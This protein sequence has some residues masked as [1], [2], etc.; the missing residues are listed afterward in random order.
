MMLSLFTVLFT[1]CSKDNTTVQVPAAGYETSEQAYTGDEIKAFL[2][3]VKGK[4]ELDT[5][6]TYTLAQTIALTADGIL[7]DYSHADKIDK[8]AMVS[9]DSVNVTYSGTP[10]GSADVTSVYNAVLNK[11]SAMANAITTPNLWLLGIDLRTTNVTATSARIHIACIFTDGSTA[12]YGPVVPPPPVPTIPYSLKMWSVGDCAM[13]YPGVPGAPKVIERYVRENQ[14]A[15]MYVPNPRL[16]R[17]RFFGMNG[18]PPFRSQH[19]IN[20]CMTLNPSDPVAGDGS[21]DTRSLYFDCGGNCN[22]VSFL[23][24]VE[25]ITQAEM[26]YH[27]PQIL[28]IFDEERLYHSNQYL[29]FINID[30]FSGN[31]Y[32][33][34]RVWLLSGASFDIISEDNP[35]PSPGSIR[36]L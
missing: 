33:D 24:D 7:Y 2:T 1:Q 35:I 3:L 20:N 23:S 4:N 15:L 10:L 36:S 21:V 6:T 14:G 5:R 31:S 18:N 22:S 13:M 34:R 29:T 19:L 16:T 17:W 26:N 12:L 32:N 9:V 25:C 30:G 8:E 27:A 11:A 28:A